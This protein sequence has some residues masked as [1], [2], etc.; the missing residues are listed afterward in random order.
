[1]KSRTGDPARKSRCF[2]YVLIFILIWVPVGFVLAQLVRAD[3][4]K[5]PE[6]Q[7]TEAIAMQEMTQRR[8]LLVQYLARD[9]SAADL[10]KLLADAKASAADMTRQLKALHE[11]LAGVSDRCGMHP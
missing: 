10:A 1:M 3:E 4:P 2:R 5:S 7:A 8:D 9:A 11:E 6:V